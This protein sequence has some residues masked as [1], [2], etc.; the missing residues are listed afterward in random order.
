MVKSVLYSKSLEMLDQ[1]FHFLFDYMWERDSVTILWK[2]LKV[3]W[4]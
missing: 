2:D 4:L 1:S 3:F